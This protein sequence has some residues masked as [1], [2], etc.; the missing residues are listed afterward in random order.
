MEELE[1]LED[2]KLYDA[3]KN[4]NKPAISKNK[5]MAIIEAERKKLG[6]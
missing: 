3:S 5:A 4:D 1:K 2:I 6:K